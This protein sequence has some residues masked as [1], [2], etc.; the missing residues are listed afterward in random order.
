[1]SGHTH[2]VVRPCTVYSVYNER[3]GTLLIES[4]WCDGQAFNVQDLSQELLEKF[5]AELA[6]AIADRLF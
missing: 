4:A 6:Q 5:R 2:E 3:T 1:M